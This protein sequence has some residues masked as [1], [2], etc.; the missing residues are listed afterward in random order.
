MTLKMKIKVMSKLIFSSFL[1]VI[2]SSII[3]MF[4]DETKSIVLW[5]AIYFFP[6]YFFLS[7]LFNYIVL[8]MNLKYIN[9]FFRKKRHLYIVSIFLIIL[10]LVSYSHCFYEITLF[11][12]LVNFFAFTFSV[13]IHQQILSKPDNSDMQ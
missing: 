8:K 2:I 10:L 11:S 1:G 9:I 5:M 7:V 12:F 3:L 4:Q 6:M 13:L